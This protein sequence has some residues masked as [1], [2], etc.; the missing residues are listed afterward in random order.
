L[1]PFQDPEATQLFAFVVD[2]V[3]AAELP[4][5][6]CNGRT[7]IVTVTGGGVVEVETRTSTVLAVLP[8]G[9]EQVNV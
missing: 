1:V 8:P 6:I 2:Q 3:S 9:P 7:P 4:A 5:T